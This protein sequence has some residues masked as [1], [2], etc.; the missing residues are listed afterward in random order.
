[1]LL[2]L[3]VASGALAANGASY[4]IIAP[5]NYCP[6]VQPLADWKTEKGLPARVV[7]LSVTGTTAAEIRNY[8][9][10][11]YDSWPVPPRYI[12]IA[13]SPDLVPASRPSS[14]DS[15]GDMTGDYEV[16]IP[17]GRFFATTPTEC[18][19]LV[20]KTIIYERTP[21]SSGDSGWMLRGTT[22]VREDN[23]PDT[24]YQP[25]CRHVRGLWDAAGFA[26]TESLM[27]IWGDDRD[28]IR[29]AINEGRGFVLHRGRAVGDWRTPFDHVDP[30]TLSNGDM[31]PVVVSGSCQT[32][33]LN[34]GETMIADEFVRAG[35]P[36]ARRGA[37][38]YFGTSHVGNYIS[39]QRGT[40]TRGF[41]DAV[42]LEGRDR[43]GDACLRGKHRLDSLLPSQFFYEEWN[44]LG[45]PELPLW[46]GAPISLDV[47][48]PDHVPLGSSALTVDVASAGVPLANAVVCLSSHRDTTIYFTDITGSDGHVEFPLTLTQLDDTLNVTVTG[49][50]IVPYQGIA[51]SVAPDMGAAAILSPADRATPGPITPS[52]RI[53]NY[54]DTRPACE[55]IFT[56]N[57][58]PAYCDSTIFPAGLPGD[59]TVIFRTWNADVGTFTARCSTV[60]FG[61]AV[62]SNNACGRT[63]TVL[64]TG[65]HA[66]APMPDAESGRQMKAGAWLA[67]DAASNAVYASK[68]DKTGEFFRYNPVTDSWAALPEMP[69]GAG[70]RKP[71]A[72]SA[73][74]ADGEGRVYATRGNNTLD[75]YA[76]TGSAWSALEAV[77]LG[78]GKKVKGGTD[79]AYAEQGDTS[80]FVYL[81]KGYGNEFYRFN[82]AT[83]HWAQLAPAP[84]GGNQKW[85]KGSWLAYD[86]ANTIYAHKAKYSELYAYDLTTGAWGANL[87][88]IPLPSGITGKNK[89]AKDGGS[90]AMIDG[91]I[92]ALKGGNTNEFW[93][94]SPSGTWA[95]LDTLPQVSPRGAGKKKKV[96]SGGCMITD[97]LIL[98]ATKG[99]RTNELWS[100]VPVRQAM[101]PAPDRTDGVLASGIAPST[102]LRMTA[103]VNRHGTAAIR[104]QLPV[105][106]PAR[107][108]VFDVTGRLVMTRS[109]ILDR[110]GT[111]Y[112]DLAALSDGTYLV[113]LNTAGQSATGRITL[114]R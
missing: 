77:P 58:N 32:V 113:K 29:A 54:R 39:F 46:T 100:Y 110:T 71:A 73:G 37:V 50:N 97:G 10:A 38:A 89:K 15:Y 52:A 70:G 61:D 64:S 84:V 57:S 40:V 43:L 95:E 99:N 105:A 69:D 18:S 55:V 49:K 106:G 104:Y 92:Y 102:G 34:A 111:T 53:V 109:L 41:F 26:K 6:I 96:N 78:A 75:F 21:F 48:H 51:M 25:D 91:S 80:S 59:T 47:S 94:R 90:A 7:P 85:D 42:F 81:L 82:T 35:T 27:S 72:G 114:I 45:D 56:V 11:A 3:A 107:I 60:T 33:T 8:I 4:L 19:T 31:L 63:V 16:E 79:M 22:I 23:P 74:C 103:T 20:A 28:T 17:V 112:L 1:M 13:G 2:L 108:T 66:L 9:V 87:G 76:L 14:D 88:D 86:G 93:R 44:L 83:G 12:L 65:W 101:S 5:D 98:F 67:C 24:N 62:L 68:G 30:G 36:Q